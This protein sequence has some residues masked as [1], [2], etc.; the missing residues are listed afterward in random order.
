MDRC[1]CLSSKAYSL[2][3]DIGLSLSGKTTPVW[4]LLRPLSLSARCSLTIAFP[5]TDGPRRADHR[6]GSHLEDPASS[7]LYNII[8]DGP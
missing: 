3:M 1:I 5:G 7:A 4:A 6:E 8:L 2:I